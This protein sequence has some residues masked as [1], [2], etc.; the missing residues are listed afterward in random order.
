MD[1][2]T[3]QRIIADET[4]AFL[5]SQFAPLDLSGSPGLQKPATEEFAPEDKNGLNRVVLSGSNPLKALAQNPDAEA[6]AQIA[7]E[8]GDTELAERLQDDREGTA[9][10]E[11]VRTHQSYYPDDNNFEAMK[12][13]LDDH[14]LEFTTE[15][16]HNA[17]VALTRA[18]DLQMRPGTAKSL[19]KAEQLHVISLAK[20]GQV[21]DAISTFLSYSLPD[22]EDQWEDETA[23]LSDPDTLAVRNRACYFVWKQSRPI[24]ETAAWHEFLRQYFAGRPIRTVADYDAAWQQFEQHERS[25]YRDQLLSSN[26]TEPSPEKVAQTLDDLSDDEIEKLTTET[27]R[28]RARSSRRGTGVLA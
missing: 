15:N 9:A 25:A 24:L 16:L 3:R 4:S 5:D 28:H 2:Q 10:E 1:E 8:T 18:G 13:Y 20:A 21:A 19:S 27:R 14:R 23:F 26:R 11:F 7:R 22:A 6:L 17:F 12:S